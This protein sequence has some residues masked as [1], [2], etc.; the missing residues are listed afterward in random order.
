[1]NKNFEDDILF[2]SETFEQHLER[3]ET[4]FKML[5][6][7][8]LRIKSQKCAFLQ[9]SVKFLGHQVSAEGMEG[10]NYS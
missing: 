6:E 8:G 9:Q 10:P 7:T 3:L 1:M 2:F 4:V 5:A